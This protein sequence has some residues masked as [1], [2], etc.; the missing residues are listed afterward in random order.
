MACVR[1]RE[2]CR[3]CRGR[4]PATEPPLR[5]QDPVPYL[6]PCGV[7]SSEA[8]SSSRRRSLHVQAA[9]RLVTPG[10]PVDSA[11]PRL[12]PRPWLRPPRCRV[13]GVPGGGGPDLHRTA[14]PQLGHQPVRLDHRP[15][16]L[17]P[18]APSALSD[19]SR[20][21]G[22]LRARE[23]L[24]C[25]PRRAQWSVSHRREQGCSVRRNVGGPQWRLRDRWEFQSA[26]PPAP[27]TLTSAASSVRERVRSSRR[28]IRATSAGKSGRRGWHQRSHGGA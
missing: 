2:R 24:L 20:A 12:G 15:V 5:R 21:S 23:T 14:P 11:V 28:V 27:R 9:H 6:T 4:P 7:T 18:T 25:P 16:R 22:Q 8:G 13:D 26:R 3:A 1:C 19:A 10:Q 17:P